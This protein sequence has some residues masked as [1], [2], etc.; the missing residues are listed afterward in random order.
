MTVAE[1]AK[2][3]PSDVMH[4]CITGGEPFLHDLEELA[5]YLSNHDI[6]VHVET[7]GTLPVD[8]A[9]PSG[10]LSTEGLTLPIGD[11]QFAPIWIT[12]SPKYPVLPEMILLANEIK[13]LVDPDFNPDKLPKEVF[14]HPLVYIQPV[15]FEHKINGDNLKLA[16]EWQQKYPQWRVSVQLHK[17]LEAATEQRVR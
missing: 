10:T 7:S 1:I 5:I 15:N 9:F 6:Q 11:S 12:C 3:V 13:L 17:A 14:K 2:E 8:K 16:M 4:A